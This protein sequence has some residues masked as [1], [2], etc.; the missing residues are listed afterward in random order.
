MNQQ[1]SRKKFTELDDI[2][3][4]QFVNQMK[5]PD[6]KK[7]SY[8]M[9]KWSPRQCRD[10]YNNYL[11][12]KVQNKKWTEDE[13]RLLLEKYSLFGPKWSFLTRFFKDRAAANI[14]NHY[15]K[16]TFKTLQKNNRNEKLKECSN[17]DDDSFETPAIETNNKE[18]SKDIFD[19]CKKLSFKPDL[20]DSDDSQ[21]EIDHDYLDFPVGFFSNEIFN[22]TI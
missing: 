20:D 3:L 21:F 9:Q 17:D 2:K 5:K 1:R 19:V 18:N 10:R 4:I 11:S 15:A 22:F 12:P 8:L 6:W 16:L 13:D 14:K 7:I